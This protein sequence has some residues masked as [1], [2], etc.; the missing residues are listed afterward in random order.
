MSR[1]I[2]WYAERISGEA[3]ARRTASALPAPGTVWS[4]A[5]SGEALSVAI[6]ATAIGGLFV[7][8]GYCGHGVMQS[9]A[10]SR[11]LV[12]VVTGAAEPDSPFRVDRPFD[13]RSHL[14]P[15]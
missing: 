3:L 12:D 5:S 2:V 8:T 9:P 14:D 6:R 13:A 7:N 4:T 10:G 15:L 1:R 11:R